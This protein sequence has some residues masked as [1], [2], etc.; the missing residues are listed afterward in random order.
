MCKVIEACEQEDVILTSGQSNWILY[1][2]GTRS[3]SSNKNEYLCPSG[4]NKTTCEGF[5]VAETQMQK[6][7][8]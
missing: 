7:Q 3:N 2:D 4:L 8:S 6:T 5:A 1:T